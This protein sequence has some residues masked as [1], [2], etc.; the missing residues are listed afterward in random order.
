MSSL[1][2]SVIAHSKKCGLWEFVV[3]FWVRVERVDVNF[4]VY[5]FDEMSFGK[6]ENRQV[7]N[8]HEPEATYVRLAKS[9]LR[10][11]FLAVVVLVE[12]PLLR[13]G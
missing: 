12:W 10:L 9:Q 5:H 13:C 8:I 4:K 6:K 7:G 11:R 3:R 2:C 1:E